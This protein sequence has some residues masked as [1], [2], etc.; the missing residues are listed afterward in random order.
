[1]RRGTACAAVPDHLMERP[2][3]SHDGD[4]RRV[5]DRRE[6]GATDPTET[7]YGEGAALHLIGLELAF[8]RELGE[9]AHLLGDVDHNFLSAS[10]M[11]GT[12]RPCGVSAA[13][14]I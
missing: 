12:T 11:T 3:R 14:P 9:I 10:R 6:I 8:A 5:D 4:L 2:A 13:N 7:R 1:M